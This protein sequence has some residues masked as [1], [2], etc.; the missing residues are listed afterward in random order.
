[1]DY[2]SREHRGEHLHRRDSSEQRGI[3]YTILTNRSCR[4]GKGTLIAIVK[5]VS[6]DKV[7]EVIMR[8]DE[9]RRSVVREITMDMSN[10]MH[11]I[12]KRSFPNAMRTIDRFHIQ[13]LANDALQEMRIAHRWDTI[14][15]DTDAR[16]EAKCQGNPYTPVVLTNGDTPRLL[17]ARSRY[18]LFKSV[19]A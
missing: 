12:A 1:M 5:G 18:L 3:L 14:Q 10:S 6:A 16:E 11:L 13:K 15:A 2:L 9:Q 7:T 8:I 4:G 19:S 17:P